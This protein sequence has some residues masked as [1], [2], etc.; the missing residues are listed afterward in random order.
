MPEEKQNPEV[1]ELQAAPQSPTP[2]ALRDR[3]V[4]PEGVV[5]KQAQGYVVAGL[6]VLILLAVMFSKNH[7]KTT[8]AALPNATP[9]SSDANAR[10]IAELEQN[11]TAEQRQSQ[12]QAQQQKASAGTTTAGTQTPTQVGGTVAPA[13]QSPAPTV[14]EPPR[15]PIADA[16]KAMAF[17]AR[18]ASNLVSADAGTSR[19]SASPADSADAIAR[20]E[21][22]A[23]TPA[24]RSAN[25]PS[26]A[27]AT[28]TAAETKR[29]PEVNL[30]SAHG[31]PFVLYEGTTID[32]VLTNRLDGEFAGPVKVMVS[33]PIYSH[34]GQHVLIP[35]GSFLLGGTQKVAGFGQK[36]LAVTFHRLIM[37]DG[38][39]VDLDQFHGLD[40]I[41]DTGLKDKTNNH[42]LEIFGTSIALGVIAGAAEATTNS[43]YNETGSEAYRQ[44][45]SSSLSQSSANV[46][47]RFI[48]IPPTI[49]ITEGHR[50]KVYLT[51]DMLL[52]AYENHD[53]PGV[54]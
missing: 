11:L 28:Q 20:P 53:M 48:N 17:K 46:L 21:T 52:P 35:E 33:N 34:D 16:E 32:T 2:P 13:T 18:F 36:R 15:D 19:P 3:R 45:I 42:Y 37:P 49:T 14:T 9:F 5:P 24:P 31:Q 54:F 29:A 7:A 38:Y 51:Q 25:S 6:A 27:S 41:G 30:N 1:S 40:Q 4:L 12:Q 10:K 50:I 8:P 22:D 47:N 23:A 39:S 26:Q 44:G 43:G